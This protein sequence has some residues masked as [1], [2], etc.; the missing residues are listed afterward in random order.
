MT[1]DKMKKLLYM[2]CH[3]ILEFQEVSLF[4]ELGYDVYSMGAYSNPAQAGILRP[5]IPGAKPH[6]Q[7]HAVYLQSSKENI[8]Q[9]LVDWADLI[10]M[11]HNSRVDV[12]DHPQPWLGST[13]VNSE[14]KTEDNWEKLKKKPVIWRSIG[15][16]TK[17]IEESLKPYRDDGLKIVRYSPKEK[18]IPSY[19]G[20]DAMIRFYEDEN[21]FKGWTGEKKQV[22]T[23][24]Q[25]MKSRGDACNFRAFLEATEPFERRL[26]GPGNEDAGLIGGQLTYEQLKQELR[27]SRVYFYTGTQPASY[28]LNFIEAL[29]TG[30]PIVAIGK[31]FYRQFPDQDTYEVPEIIKNGENGFVSDSIEELQ[32]YIQLLM[33]DYELAKK[34]GENGRKTAIELFGK[35]K[36]KEEWRLFL[37]RILNNVKS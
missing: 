8:H 15:Q 6:P 23:I 32:K 36:I 16:S 17:E 21:E 5:A 31:S 3:E 13:R 24:A 35:E 19:C 7:L 30:I 29:M 33:D 28:T 1:K 12:V 4:V 9:E 11:M 27:T 2:S 14:G 37:E 26:F 34:I 25:S 10:V 20:E 22:I 18:T